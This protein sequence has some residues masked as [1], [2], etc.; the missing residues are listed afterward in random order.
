MK[1]IPAGS[2]LPAL[3]LWIIWNVLP[4]SASFRS[5]KMKHK[6]SSAERA[7]YDISFCLHKSLTIFLP[8]G[9]T[10]PAAKPLL[11]HWLSPS[12]CRGGLEEKMWDKSKP[13]QTKPLVCWENDTSISKGK[14]KKEVAGSKA[15]THYHLPTE[16]QA[17]I[18][19]E[20]ISVSFIAEASVAW[21]G[22]SLGSVVIG[23]PGCAVSPPNLLLSTRLLFGATE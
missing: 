7:L 1:K 11:S 3:I 21:H 19:L 12:G 6:A 18:T 4:V 14:N 15:V 2:V 10:W 22:I 9:W 8:L 17:T 13:N 5:V 23:C 20:K 16:Q